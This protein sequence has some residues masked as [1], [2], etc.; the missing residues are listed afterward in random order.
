MQ[1]RSP[2]Q[3]V[4]YQFLIDNIT[5]LN[6]ADSAL[7]RNV[8]KDNI[9]S[10]P[11]GT[12]CSVRQRPPFFD[13]TGHEKMFWNNPQIINAKLCAVI[14]QYEEIRIIVAGNPLNK[15]VISAVSD[16]IAYST[17]FAF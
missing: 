15:S 14:A 17:A 7:H 9:T 11:T 13:N 2:A 16:S 3:F 12:L 5:V 8:R 1:Q 6:N 10:Y 4:H